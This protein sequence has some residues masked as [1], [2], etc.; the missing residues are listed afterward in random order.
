M[1]MLTWIV[2]GALAAAASVAGAQPIPQSHEHDEAT[3]QHQVSGQHQ[4]AASNENCC[5]EEMMHKMMQMMQ[6]H[7]GTGTEKDA[8]SKQ[9]HSH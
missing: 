2:G 5:C 4:A 8:P 1:L 7:Q 9:D 3:A 6:Q